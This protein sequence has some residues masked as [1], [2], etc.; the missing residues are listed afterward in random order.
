MARPLKIHPSLIAADE[1]LLS[2]S[3]QL[4]GQDINSGKVKRWPQV[5]DYISVTRMPKDLG[6][7]A[8]VFKKSRAESCD[9]WRI[10]D[11]LKLSKLTGAAPEKLFNLLVTMA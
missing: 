8:T 11:I 9:A 4:L 7:N 2:Q 6:M 3:Y 10:S 1:V 5:W